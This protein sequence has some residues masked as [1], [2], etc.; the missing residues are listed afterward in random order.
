[1]ILQLELFVFIVKMQRFLVIFIK[2]KF[3]PQKL[4]FFEILFE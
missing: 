4:D 2:K 3:D 1:M